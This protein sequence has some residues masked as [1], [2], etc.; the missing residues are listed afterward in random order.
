MADCWLWYGIFAD[1]VLEIRH[2]NNRRDVLRYI[3]ED[4]IR[5][6][7]ILAAGGLLIPCGQVNHDP[8]FKCNYM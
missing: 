3:A 5:Q 2:V 8:C 1:E 7:D 6:E 4:E